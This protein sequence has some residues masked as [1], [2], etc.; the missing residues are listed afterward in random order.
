MN[1]GIVGRARSGKDTAG[2]WLVQNRGYERVSFADPLKACAL[3]LNPW[4]DGPTPPYSDGWRMRLSDMVEH[5]G[6]ERAK[7]DFPEVRRVLQHIGMGVR[8]LDPEF[9]L[10]LAIARV[11]EINEAGRPAVI[12][13]VRFRNERDSL[14]R[15]GFHLVHVE[16]P[17][18]PHLPPHPSEG[19]LTA[20][21]THFMIVN[22]KTIEYF[23][24]R[25]ELI[26]DEVLAIS[27]ARH[28]AKSHE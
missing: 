20:E 4:I 6:W 15:A 8:S 13:D 5:L 7:E 28:Y 17:A 21:D 10:R 12:T 23:N 9:W 27:S 19:A 18:A 1:I 26:A 11:R 3:E 24:S 22:N 25:V 16:R 14:M 2:V